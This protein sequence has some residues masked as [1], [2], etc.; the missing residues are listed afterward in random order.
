MSHENIEAAASVKG[1]TQLTPICA[2]WL[3]R[4]SRPEA[5]DYWVEG[6]ANGWNMTLTWQGCATTQALVNNARIFLEGCRGLSRFTI[7][8]E[9]Q[10]QSPAY[11]CADRC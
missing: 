4:R 1:R 9:R 3:S 6:S 2:N 10:N 5:P 11:R 8:A 7:S